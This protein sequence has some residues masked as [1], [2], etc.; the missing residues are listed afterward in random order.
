[1]VSLHVH[2]RQFL[3][4]ECFGPLFPLCLVPTF[5]FTIPC[6]P[7]DHVTSKNGHVWALPLDEL[8]HLLGGGSVLGGVFA[9]V[10]ISDLY[11]LQFIVCV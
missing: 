3:V 9:V 10:D 5:G 1:M 6:I 4:Y 11:D 2:V 8:L 7:A